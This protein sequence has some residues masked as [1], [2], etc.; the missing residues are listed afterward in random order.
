MGEL[1]GG[2]A[3][4]DPVNEA[5]AL[6]LERAMREIPG[7]KRKLLK[8]C[9]VDR[10]RPEVV[11]RVLRIPHRPIEIFKQRLRDAQAAIEKLV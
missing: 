2:S 4:R 1:A 11:C 6:Q 9:Y 10:E 5:D 8:I 7:D 3:V